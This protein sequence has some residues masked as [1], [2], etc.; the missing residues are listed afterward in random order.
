MDRIAQTTTF[1][2]IQLGNA[3]P[4]RLQVQIGI[5]NTA[6]DR[7]RIDLGD[8]RAVTLGVST[9][10][11]LMSLNTTGGAQQA[12]TDLDTALNSVNSQRSIYGA[13]QNRIESA[14]RNL[15]NYTENLS[16]ARSRIVDAD[17]ASETAQLA[18]YQIL[19]Q[20]GVA[21]LGQANA[22]GQAA[23]RLLG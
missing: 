15:A 23:L 12:L 18:K 11:G 2:G 6:N 7:I 5:N 4:T 1:N 14:L 3:S 13:T 19:Q 17:F 16:A 8:L 21:I 22:V 10:L 9:G 20:S